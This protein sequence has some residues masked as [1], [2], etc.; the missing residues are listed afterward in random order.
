MDWLQTIIPLTRQKAQKLGIINVK[1]KAKRIKKYEDDIKK[2]ATFSQGV[3][4]TRTFQQAF[5]SVIL[6]NY[7]RRCAVCD[8]NDDVFLRGCHIVPVKHDLSIAAELENGICLCVL[9]D[10]AFENGI[11]SIS[12]TYRIIIANS[13]KSTSAVLGSL[14]SKLNG[15]KI[16]L[17]VRYT[18]DKSYLKRHRDIHSI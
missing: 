4:K 15:K 10:I 14:I 6:D 11:F 16:R 17:S 8:V 1:E 2:G 9:H 3:V 12:D 13:F 5:R 18:P 7:Q